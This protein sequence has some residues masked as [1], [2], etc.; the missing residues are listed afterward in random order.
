MSHSVFAS[1]GWMARLHA[2]QLRTRVMES[3]AMSG[4][5]QNVSSLLCLCDG[6]RSAAC[7]RIFRA[8]DIV[9]VVVFRCVKTT[10]T[11]KF[12]GSTSYSTLFT[13]TNTNAHMQTHSK[14]F[15]HLNAF[16]A[17][18]LKKRKF[19]KPCY[20]VYTSDE[21][22]FRQICTNKVMV[23]VHNMYDITL[24]TFLVCSYIF[25]HVTVHQTRA[26][27]AFRP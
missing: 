12:A 20:T 10:P 3:H 1:F 5:S 19:S 21:F 26:H 15:P 16:H 9:D 11:R 14:R 25:R 7:R 22:I 2:E 6:I 18:E 13:R 24:N 23:I 17:L 4:V 8:V 27:R